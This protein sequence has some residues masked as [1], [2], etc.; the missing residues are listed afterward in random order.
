[1]SSTL[2]SRFSIALALTALAQ[3]GCGG[4][5]G[6]SDQGGPRAEARQVAAPAPRAG[7][8]R[9]HE[10]VRAE[11]EHA[12]PERELRRQ[13]GDRGADKAARP[14]RNPVELLLGTGT[15]RPP[16]PRRKLSPA[17]ERLLRDGPGRRSGNKPRSPGKLSPEL[18]ALLEAAGSTR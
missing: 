14:A 13:V 15:R 11:E 12:M 3:A 18:R 4:A 1:M 8:E 6:Q 7:V 10:P 17:L 16:A 2:W 9:P 5:S